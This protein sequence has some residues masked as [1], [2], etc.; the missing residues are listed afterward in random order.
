MLLGAGSGGLALS[1]VIALSIVVPLAALAVI[2]WFFWRSAR[3]F[4]AEQE[5]RPGP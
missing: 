1:V 5:R 2:C 4:D 3:R